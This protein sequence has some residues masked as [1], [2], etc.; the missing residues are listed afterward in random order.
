M[1]KKFESVYNKSIS[2]V[3]EEEPSFELFIKGIVTDVE[4]TLKD[5]DKISDELIQKYKKRIN[6]TK[7]QWLRNYKKPNSSLRNELDRMLESSYEVMKHE[8]REE[9]FKNAFGGENPEEVKALRLVKLEQWKNDDEKLLSDYPY[10]FKLGLRSKKAAINNDVYYTLLNY[11]AKNQRDESIPTVPEIATQQPYSYRRTK[12]KK[13]D[14]SIIERA[15]PGSEFMIGQRFID[16]NSY[17]ESRANVEALRKQEMAQML[18]EL[19]VTDLYVFVAVMEEA[20]KDESF[21]ATNTI[22]V[23]IGT[24]VRRA[25]KSQGK[26]NY[27]AA[28]QSLHR[29]ENVKTSVYNENLH[30][31]T[32]QLFNS[33][34]IIPQGNKEYANIIV[35]SNVVK[36]YI[37]GNTISMYKHIIDSF[38]LPTSKLG[39][40]AIQRERIRVDANSKGGDR[41]LFKGTLNFFKTVLNFPNNRK[42]DNMTVVSNMLQEIKESNAVIKDFRQVSDGFIIEFYPISKEERQDLLGNSRTTFSRTPLLERL[43]DR[44]Q[45]N[46]EVYDL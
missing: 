23:D 44:E 46:L 9:H 14:L 32:I 1:L 20:L 38:Q 13:I 41:L 4:L 2:Q 30:N 10:F 36:Q 16:D 39:I 43:V 6:S 40:F 27:V 19:N 18:S 34:E 35:D 45:E 42:K 26:N 31:I 24:I 12:P 33:A 22:I 5:E 15:E 29:L 7:N 17:F 21:F 37:E 11:L 3:S 8:G 25:F 28:K